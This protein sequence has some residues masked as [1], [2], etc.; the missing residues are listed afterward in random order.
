[1][2]HMLRQ[3]ET[4]LWTFVMPP[5][6][7]FFIGTI[8]AGFGDEGTP[9]RL[10]LETPPGAG[11]LAGELVRMLEQQGFEVR[12]D[13]GDGAKQTQQTEDSRRLALP[14]A[15]TD[16]VLAGRRVT[17][18]LTTPEEGTDRDYDRLRVARAVYGLVGDVALAAE[19]GRPVNAAEL[20]RIASLPRTLNLNVTEA[21]RRTRVPTGFEQSIPGTMVMFTLL[22]ML[23]SGAILLV[24]ERQQGLLRRLASAPLPRGGIVL[25]KWAGRMALGLVQIAFAM[26]AGTLLFRMRWGPDLTMLLL[27]LVAWA[28]LAAALGLLLGNLARSEGQATAVGVLASNVL[29]ALGGCWWP[30]E[31][32]PAWMQRLALFLPT[33]ITMDALH[34][35]VSFES[36]AASAL[37]HVIALAL[38]AAA[39]GFAAT[40]TFRF[41]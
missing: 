38:G 17:V 10:L 3:R 35:L 36:G 28:A 5:V 23:T 20:S 39:A 14:A 29:A 27:V 30:I 4:L 37:P 1:M 19:S 11:F 22:V 18:R 31:I 8:T 25:G 41:Q 7:F 24:I 2:R 26:L 40:R 6:F 9:P 33:G 12:Q 15:F 13:G 16:S 21:G 32:T 34:R